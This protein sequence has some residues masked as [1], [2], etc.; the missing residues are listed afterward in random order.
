[1]SH[2]VRE[3]RIAADM[4][5]RHNR[6]VQ[7]GTQSRT[8]GGWANVIDVIRSG[9]LGRLLVAR[10]L[11]YKSRYGN[12]SNGVVASVR[13]MGTPQQLDFNLW[14]GPAPMRPYH[15][16]LVPY[17]WHW[18]W[19]FGNGDIGNQGVHEMDKARWAIAG[20][21]LP[22]S[23]LSLGGRFGYKDQGQTP[24]TQIA[25]FD[26]GDAQLIFEVRGLKA[27]PY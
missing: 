14:T 24:N 21:T 9:Q 1:M 26:Y 20:A 16:N 19:D 8:E 23:V 15:E 17:R 27:E 11:C 5:R 7:H 10:G 18:F 3:G 4:A 12:G 13:R 2:N 22:R 25:V 6:I